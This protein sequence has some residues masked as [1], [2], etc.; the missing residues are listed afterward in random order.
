MCVCVCVYA[1]IHEQFED[2]W[3]PVNRMSLV[4]SPKR[5]SNCKKG[6]EVFLPD[7]NFWYTKV[8]ERWHSVLEKSQIFL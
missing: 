5:I 7:V 3:I 1:L 6:T 2:E 4:T 8:L